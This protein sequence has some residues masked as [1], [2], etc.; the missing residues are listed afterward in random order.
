MCASSALDDG[1]E[2][3][4]RLHG[5]EGSRAGYEGNAA[6]IDLIEQ[7]V[8]DQ[9]ID[10]DFQRI[11]GY[12]FA[13]KGNDVESFKREMEAAHRAGF[14]GVRLMEKHC[15]S[16]CRMEAPVLVFPEQARF[17]PLKYLYGLCAAV[18][19]MGV[20]IFTGCRVTNVNG[21]DPKKHT[22]C[23]AQIDGG[24]IAIRS[25]AV[26]VATN[27]PAPINDWM[28]IYLKQSSYRTYV[29][30]F[31]VPRGSIE[32]ALFWDNE[33]PYHYIRLMNDG[34]GELLIVGGEDHKVGQFPDG[35]SPFAKLEAWTRYKFPSAGEVVSRWS[36]QVQ[37]PSDYFAF[38]GKAPTSGENVYVVTGDSGMGLTH[39]SLAGIILTDLIMG[40]ENRWAKFY[41]PSRRKLDS[42]LVKENVNAV[43]QLT[44]WLT[45]GE[46]KSPDDVPRGEGRLMRQ[47]LK[48]VCVYRDDSGAV[49]R[50]SAA[51]THLGGVVQW[52]PVEKSWDCPLHG[53]RFDPTGKVLMGP[54][55]DDLRQSE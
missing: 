30:G 15:L 18:E 2:E 16:G 22:P 47:G 24:K 54:A 5:Q 37:E 6:G 31:R 20:K 11:S 49:H 53:S 32:N 10:C 26:I 38:I 4:E 28:G 25:D 36:G 17:H 44:D 14:G 19:K 48:K 46:V 9:K 39:G 42:D 8:R 35:E 52:N 34:D 50:C 1:F 13:G 41:D 27:T 40:R 12:L 7:I 45:G 3:V 23:E 51:C 29:V 43:A 55:I 33:D 21:A